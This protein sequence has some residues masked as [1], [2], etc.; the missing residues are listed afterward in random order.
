ML[1]SKYNIMP[2][3]KNSSQTLELLSNNTE[4]SVFYDN[5]TNQKVQSILD[6]VLMKI[7]D[8]KIQS[9]DISHFKE[10]DMWKLINLLNKNMTEFEKWIYE[11]SFDTV[12]YY[13]ELN[14]TI[15]Y[16]YDLIYD[17]LIRKK[18]YKIAKKISKDLLNILL[19]YKKW[20]IEW[21]LESY[22]EDKKFFNV[23]KLWFNDLNTPI[24]KV[25]LERYEFTKKM[26]E[27]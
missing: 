19:D 11:I 17:F 1:I 15:N 2:L 14:L 22:W 26:L 20:E 10:K 13:R 27:K 7:D 21:I 9:F 12:I 23:K 24:A 8:K 18:E 16:I 4:K 5:S 3:D 6:M 25:W